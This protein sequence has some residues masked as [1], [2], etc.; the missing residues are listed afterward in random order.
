MVY[1]FAKTAWG[2]G[3]ATEIASAIA[4]YAFGE[5]GLKRIISLIEPQNEAS[6][7]VARKIDMRYEKDVLRPGD[8]TMRVY[9]KTKANQKSNIPYDIFSKQ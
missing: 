9:S 7:I 2:N 4:D 6:E 5:L 1:V 8:K 3:Y